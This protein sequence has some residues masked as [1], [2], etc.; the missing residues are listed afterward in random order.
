MIEN[1]KGKGAAFE[2]AKKE[3]ATDGLKRALRNFGNVL[4]NCLYDKEYLKKVGNM[5]VK[6][7]KWH[8]NRLHRHPDFAPQP[9]EGAEKEEAD[10]VKTEPHKTPM[11]PNHAMR[12]FTGQS[13][14]TA[15]SAS[16]DAE[17]EF[18][19]NLFDG[20]EISEEQGDEFTF[21]SM[22]APKEA[23]PKAIEALKKMDS[24]DGA[25]PHRPSPG[26][27]NGPPRQAMN[28]VQSMPAMRQNGAGQPPQ[29]PQQQNQ[30]PPRPGPPPRAP[31]IPNAQQ[32]MNKPRGVPPAVDIHAPPKPSAMNGNGNSNPPQQNQPLRPTPPQAQN[33]NQ[34]G[35]LRP[36]GP[37][38]PQTP[39]ANN[40]TTKAPMGFVTSRAA[41]L[42]Q[43]ADP[44]TTS[45]ISLPAFN[46]HADSPVP[47]E[48]R[49]PGIDHT[50]SM[51][52]TREAVGA[53]PAPEPPAQGRPAAA[54]SGTG[55]FQRPTMNRSNFVNPQQDGGRRIG[56]PNGGA[57]AHAMSPLAN[58]G[59]YKQP[60]MVG[61]VKRPALAD[62][63][64]QGGKGDGSGE[65]HEA[66]KQR[67]DGV[68]GDVENA[69]GS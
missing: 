50:R 55:Q 28:R 56:M 14:R 63:S 8:E 11:K 18:G 10:G 27:Q 17:D 35:P 52:I 37:G 3:A 66:K 65:G 36:N 7:I 57:G 4:G 15:S 32:N 39:Q 26:P 67:V 13:D 24:S 41:E 42:M 2:K 20:M 23:A 48:K 40:N 38:Q 45:T 51:K 29:Q 30:G 64:N 25:A 60:S 49:T 21:E 69:L 61:G 46:P 43:N 22:P 12:T 19:G 9:A 62:V 5:K 54:G 47:A 53:P 16:L 34:N 58:R 33:Q 6:P 59:G 44:S 31:Q 1:C 68:V